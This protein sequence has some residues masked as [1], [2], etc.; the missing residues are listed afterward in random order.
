MQNLRTLFD[1]RTLI[2]SK[3]ILFIILAFAFGV[4]CRLEWVVYANGINE[5]F[6][7]GEI[8]VNTNDGYYYA[9][10]ARDLLAGFHQDNDFSPTHTPLSKLIYLIASFGIFKFESILLYLSVF[11]SSFIVVPLVLMGREIGDK[12]SGF[13]AALIAVITNS[14]LILLHLL[15]IW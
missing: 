2:K 1:W 7:N 5:F 13:V 10:G 11:C 15:L 14:Y 3:T 9:E 8:M 12:T 4:F 6:H